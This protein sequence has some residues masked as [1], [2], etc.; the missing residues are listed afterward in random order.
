M[1]MYRFARENTTGN[2]TKSTWLIVSRCCGR[3]ITSWQ[4]FAHAYRASGSFP[5]CHVFERRTLLCIH[6]EWT[7]MQI[8]SAYDRLAFSGE[9][10]VMNSGW[11]KS[12][13]TWISGK[14]FPDMR[15]TAII[16]YVYNMYTNYLKKK[17]CVVRWSKNFPTKIGL[18][19]ALSLHNFM[20]G[21]SAILHYHGHNPVHVG[22]Y[23]WIT[24][25]SRY[26]DS[27]FKYRPIRGFVL[28]FAQ[29]RL[30]LAHQR[31]QQCLPANCFLHS[32]RSS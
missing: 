27:D 18:Q 32:W 14:W 20:D 9:I 5:A 25:P 1:Y 13:R 17:C 12:C 21:V 10:N 2:F 31:I 11:M 15:V 30:Q 19:T 4:P 22:T 24:I 7:R 3:R 23:P 26:F 16:A 29:E 28:V 8:T 6:H